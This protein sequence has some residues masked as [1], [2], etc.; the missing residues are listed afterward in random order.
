M[1]KF[2]IRL[3]LLLAFSPSAIAEGQTFRDVVFA[4]YGDFSSN[5]ELIRRL[6]SP[7]SAARLQQ[8]F[9]RKGVTL[10]AQPLNLSDERFIVHVPPQ[11]PP[12]WF[13]PSG[14]RAAVA[15]RTI[16]AG[17]G[18]GFGSIRCYFRQRSPLRQR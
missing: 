5:P 13:R 14:L 16:A 6:L 7:L 8:A 9:K 12:P 4:N 17:V 1:S 15:G 2:S 11:Q 18:E 3:C 10:A